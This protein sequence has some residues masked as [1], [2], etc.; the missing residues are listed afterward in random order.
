MVCHAVT[1][2][3]AM[4]TGSTQVWGMAPWPP[5]PQTFIRA[6]M[7]AVMKGPGV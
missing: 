1:I 4:T 2:W 7:L 3:Q 6:T 5:T